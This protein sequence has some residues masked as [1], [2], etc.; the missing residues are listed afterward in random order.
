M[1]SNLVGILLLSLLDL[2]DT[3]RA[4][5]HIPNQTEKSIP[6]WDIVEEVSALRLGDQL[7]PASSLHRKRR[8]KTEEISHDDSGINA[9]HNS[10]ATIYD[11]G[12]DSENTWRSRGESRETG[13]E[14]PGNAAPSKSSEPCTLDLPNSILTVTNAER[15]T[16][17]CVTICGWTISAL[18][19]NHSSGSL[20]NCEHAKTTRLG[21]PSRTTSIKFPATTF[22]PRPNRTSQLA[23]R[24]ESWS[25]TGIA[26]NT[27]TRTPSSP[28]STVPL[29]TNPLYVPSCTGAITHVRQMDYFTQE[30]F[31]NAWY[32][33]CFSSEKDR[34]KSAESYLIVSP[35][36]H[37]SNITFSYEPKDAT[38][39]CAM[40]CD[41]AFGSL[42]IACAG[43]D[44]SRTTPL[45]YLAPS[46]LLSLVF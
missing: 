23:T 33:V 22:E 37:T 45:Y 18:Q 14:P 2:C 21:A 4:T 31:G 7:A 5:A 25:L 35:G 27:T 8:V 16:I 43:N 3:V 42:S 41:D 44:V 9:N 15:H 46:R 29:L 34:D 20:T 24:K 38:K 6:H 12:D 30:S 19:R 13:N 11:I 1:L 10:E 26:L 17:G 28:V 39:E 36:G 40:K 32:A